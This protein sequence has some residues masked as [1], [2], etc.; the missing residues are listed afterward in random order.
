MEIA[1]A[2]P[3]FS[4]FKTTGRSR[5]TDGRIDRKIISVK[6]THNY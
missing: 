4:L 2:A 6:N 1:P 5:S 3:E